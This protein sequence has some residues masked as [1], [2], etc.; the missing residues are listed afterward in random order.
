VP[1]TVAPAP[2]QVRAEAVLEATVW[3]ATFNS[4]LVVVVYLALLADW[5][6]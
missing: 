1:I 6:A 5:L 4:L 2:Q 3:H